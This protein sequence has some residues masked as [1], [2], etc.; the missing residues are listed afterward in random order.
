M[1][2]TGPIKISQL[3]AAT[4]LN[5]ADLFPIVQGGITK[6]WSNA[7]SGGLAFV[8]ST[9]ATLKALAAPTAALFV[10]TE[11]YHSAGDGGAGTYWW[12]S[13]DTTADN[14]V[15]VLA[16]NA[17]GTGRWNL[18]HTPGVL[19]ALQASGSDIGAQVNTAIAAIGSSG[20]T[21]VLPS[22]AFSYSTTI[23]FPIT[24][25]NTG[26]TLEGQGSGGTGAATTLSYTG[27]GKGI[28]QTITNSTYQ[29]N[30]GAKLRGFTLNGGSAGAGAIG[31]Q[32]GGSNY[33]ET[34]PDFEVINFSG[35]GSVG[36]KVDNA[37][38]MFTERYRLQGAVANCTTNIQFKVETGGTASMAH[39]RVDMWMNVNASQ[40][41]IDILGGAALTDCDIWINGNLV[42]NATAA[43][44]I[45]VDAT[46]SL[47][48]SI[49][50]FIPESTGGTNTR[51]SVDAGGLLE[52]V[53]RFTSLNLSDTGTVNL[54]GWSGTDGSGTFTT[55]G[56][57]EGQNFYINP[58]DGSV[59]QS[60]N[61]AATIYHGASSA[62]PNI[63]E[64]KVGGVANS[65]KLTTTGLSNVGT[66]APGSA[67]VLGNSTGSAVG[68][69]YNS[70][71]TVTIR[72]D[73]S[74]ININKSDNSAS[75]LIMSDAGAL[76]LP[77][78]GTTAS[79]ANGFLDSTASN[80]LLR[81]TS[82]LRYKTAVEQVKAVSVLA[83]E[84]LSAI[85][86]RSTASAD[87]P[88][89]S[90]YGFAAEDVEKVDPRL[91]HYRREI[92]GYKDEQY[93]EEQQE[94]RESE[95]SDVVIRDGKPVLV[96]V[97]ATVPVVDL[98]PLTDESG[99]PVM[100][101]NEPVLY[102]VPRMKKVTLIKRVPIYGDPLADGVQYER[103]SVLTHARLMLLLS[104]LREKGFIK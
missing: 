94:T 12:N 3:P 14:G 19:N 91:V 4:T 30:A 85:W 70:S 9:V 100:Q 40:K 86:F 43:V 78:I 38:G 44:G 58:T 88:D 53:G 52:V 15:T 89:W 84:K 37:S 103:V 48:Q 27:S 17:G 69:I 73:T 87:R 11:G 80:N 10:A 47:S 95:T 64:Q 59:G 13:T 98:L 45:H 8:V 93:E 29:N 62:T 16:P 101:E 31:V 6:E 77:N 39:G 33:F 51:F 55:I 28:D 36:I 22:G 96:K 61:S 75:N 57:F 32:F 5:P 50:N 68:T 1:A 26:I 67:I 2:N 90:H 60:D 23:Q 104:E 7:V 82:S 65:L 99:D 18:I 21:V 25:T 46:S 41:G 71:H 66:F 24:G 97:K 92:I 34:A 63:V 76:Q 35:A 42:F 74:G 56:S 79:A 54:T 102:P 20:G 83:I 49:C 72:G 81:S